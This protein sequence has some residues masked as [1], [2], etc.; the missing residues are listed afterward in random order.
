MDWFH[1]LQVL[2]VFASPR[3]WGRS[4]GSVGLPSQET[5]PPRILFSFQREVQ[6]KSCSFNRH[7]DFSIP[8]QPKSLRH[9]FGGLLY[10]HHHLHA[11]LQ[12]GLGAGTCVNAY[13]GYKSFP[14]LPVWSPRSR[15][16]TRPSQ[17]MQQ[18]VTTAWATSIHLSSKQSPQGATGVL[19]EKSKHL[20][21]ADFYIQDICKTSGVLGI[22]CV[23]VANY[24][25]QILLY[26]PLPPFMP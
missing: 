2:L 25:P 8:H 3:H 9:S 11:A 21:K 10:L 1:K 19:G 26:P 16:R 13:T 7:A 12:D 23:A 17:T 22:E 18:I 4:T 15:P 24:L 14:R 6:V 20:R 5:D